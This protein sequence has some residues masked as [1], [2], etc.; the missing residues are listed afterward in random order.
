ML[1]PQWSEGQ[2]HICV[3]GQRVPLGF[4]IAEVVLYTKSPS[5][6]LVKIRQI[7]LKRETKTNGSV[8]CKL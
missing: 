4:N 5:L 7:V 3:L 2:W 1:E 6:G 8:Q